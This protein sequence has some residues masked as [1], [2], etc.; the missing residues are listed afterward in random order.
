MRNEL[1]AA[2]WEETWEPRK[3]IRWPYGPVLAD[4]ARMEESPCPTGEG[5]ERFP[6]RV[7]L[8]CGTLPA[9]W[10]LLSE[11]CREHSWASIAAV[12]VQLMSLPALQ[13]RQLRSVASVRRWIRGCCGAFDFLLFVA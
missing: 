13:Y 8:N 3:S 2:A 10:I 7:E 6:S 11:E 5:F 4:R 9:H 1:E 12:T